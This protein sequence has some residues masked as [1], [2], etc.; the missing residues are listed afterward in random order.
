MSED[1]PALVSGDEEPI[2]GKI[3]LTSAVHV[4]DADSSQAVVVEES[5]RGRNLVVQ[6]P[7]GTGKS[8]TIAN[9]IASSVHDG[10][11][12]LFV[13][14]K[15]TA[16]SVVKKRLDQVGLGAMCLEMHSRKSN[17]REVLNSLHASLSCGA[18]PCTP[19]GVR[20]RLA[21]ARDR[22]NAIDSMLHMAIGPSSYTPYKVIGMELQ[23]RDFPRHNV[24]SPINHCA[25]WDF[26]QIADARLRVADAARITAELRNLPNCDA[27]IGTCIQEQGP[28]E[29]DELRESLQICCDRLRSL[30]IE[31]LPLY[32]SFTGSSRCSVY[33]LMEFARAIRH[34]DAIPRNNTA[35]LSN[36]AWQTDQQKIKALIETGECLQGLSIIITDQLHNHAWEFDASAAISIFDKRLNS[37]FSILS[38]DYRLTLRNVRALTKKPLPKGL[39]AQI[40]ILKNLHHAQSKRREIDN[41]AQ[42]ACAALGPIWRGYETPW[43]EVKELLNWSR[44][45]AAFANSTKLFQLAAG[46]KEIAQLLELTFTIES[47]CEGLPQQL[48]EIQERTSTDTKYILQSASF[49]EAEIA[50]LGRLFEKWA[51]SM[52]VINPWAKARAALTYLRGIKLD[53]IADAVENGNISMD[54]ARAMFDRGLA[55]ALW[56]RAVEE[57]PA[58][59]AIDGRSRT[60]LVSEFRQLDRERVKSARNEVLAS[61]LNRQATAPANSVALIRGEIAK[62]RRLR[63]VRKL[64]RD[65]GDAIQRLKPVFMMS[66]LS[67]AQFLP[68]DQIKFDVL[69]I[70]EASQVTPEDAL[71]AIARSDQIIIVGDQMQL[72]PTN[73]FKRFESSDDDDV[74]ED[75]GSHNDSPGDFESIL[76]LAT[77]KG[78]ADRMLSW[79][80]RS[81]HP[82]LI[83]LSNQ[84]CYEGRL[85]LPPS[86]HIGTSTQGLSLVRTEPRHYGRGTTKSDVVQASA[87]AEAIA[88]HIEKC[89]DL[90]LGVVA[91]SG[92]QRD[93]IEDMIDQLGIR[94]N[95]EA[96]CPKPEERLIVKSVEEIQGDERDVIFISIGYGQDINGRMIQNFGPISK[97]GGHRRLNVLASRARFKCVIYSSINSG[98]IGASAQDGTKMLRSL[99]HYAEYGNFD[100]GEPKP[101]ADF[102]SPFEQEVARAIRDVGHQYHSQVGVSGFRIDLGV[103]DPLYP[104][105]FILG[106]ECDGAS[107]H[108]SRSARDRDRLR[109]EVLKGLGWQLHR[110]WSTDWFAN[111]AREKKR[112]IEAIEE[113]AQRDG[114]KEL[115]FASH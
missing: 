75:E 2:D 23:V 11:T 46:R 13:A 71:G 10:K 96:F 38:R 91:L 21:A 97:E 3:D 106:V 101:G 94:M 6:G 29:I 112:L 72:P 51:N 28:F 55:R 45:T 62:Q 27:W 63:P 108:S 79:H 41:M 95:V 87:V 30:T 103:V 60:G 56:K 85:L 24:S 54:M 105:R 92:A 110:I 26:D 61:F 109:Q 78:I 107:Y 22:L 77:R 33:D 98:D 48:L 16:L 64:M 50:P 76:T 114:A 102:D 59:Q 12:V 99:L 82:S 15:T 7:P 113:A 43:A 44:T 84:E 40:V 88:N 73:F 65:V 5:R 31:V 34:V 81:K 32:Q 111:P 104:G 69:V 18:T 83:A 14:E 49:D 100:G 4:L 9:I 53:D 67:I 37:V 8:Q 19:N 115:K 57:A 35:S 93:V 47:L 68:P 52:D 89:S 36:S 66:P 42:F 25:N 74:D 86:P 70:D 80:Y 20:K 90:S 58:L 17:K 39:A 1:I